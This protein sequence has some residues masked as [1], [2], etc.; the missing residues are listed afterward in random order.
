M[1]TLS[2]CPQT[3]SNNKKRVIQQ[4]VH[5]QECATQLQ[6]LFHNPSEDGGRV[7]A[8]EVLVQNILTSFNHTLSALSCIEVSQNQ[9][10]CNDDSPWCE[11]RRSEGCSGSGKRPGSKDRRGCYKRKYDLFILHV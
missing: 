5:G 8:E 10:T 7:S 1:A 11:D 6:I 4:L 3:L 9:T 2:P